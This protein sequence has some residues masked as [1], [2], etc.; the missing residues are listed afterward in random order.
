M[1]AK[2]V[3][4]EK[5]D[6]NLGV[7]SLELACAHALSCTYIMYVLLRLLIDYYM[8]VMCC[9]LFPDGGFRS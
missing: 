1:K 7:E 3:N 9:I 8:Y 5:T 6:L 4:E 2:S